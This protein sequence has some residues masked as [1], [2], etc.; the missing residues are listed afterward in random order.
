MSDNV[1]TWKLSYNETPYAQIM[2]FVKKPEATMVKNRFLDGTMYFATIGHP[3]PTASVSIGCWRD[4]MNDLNDI[5]ATGAQIEIT[6]RDKHY[7]GRAQELPEWT[8]V[9]N[10]YYYTGTFTFLIEEES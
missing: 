7:R 5:L 10:G 4:E 9:K 1:Y 6:Y 3:L 8:A 2:T